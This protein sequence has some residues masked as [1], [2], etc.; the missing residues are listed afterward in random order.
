MK[1]EC[2]LAV[3]R[4]AVQLTAVL[5]NRTLKRILVPWSCRG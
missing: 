4:E 1:A 5:G 3:F 2:L